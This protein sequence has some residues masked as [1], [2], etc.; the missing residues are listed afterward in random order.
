MHRME[1]AVLVSILTYSRHGRRVFI[2]AIADDTFQVHTTIKPSF[3]WAAYDHLSVKYKLDGITIRKRI[4]SRP[5]LESHADVPPAIEEICKRCEIPINGNRQLCS[6]TFQPSQ[7][8][9]L[10]N[11]NQF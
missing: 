5:D 7:L 8:G 3:E 6:L 11:P 2:E 4:K 1:A 10:M 9:D